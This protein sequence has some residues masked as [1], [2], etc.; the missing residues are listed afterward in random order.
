MV[1]LTERMRHAREAEQDALLIV[2]HFNA[3]LSMQSSA[4]FWPTIATAI[5]ARAGSDLVRARTPWEAESC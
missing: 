1:E 5:K 4:G 2:Q 3:R